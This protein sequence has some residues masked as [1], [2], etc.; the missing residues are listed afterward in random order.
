MS[1]KQDRA[2]IDRLVRE[3]VQIG[4]EL[5][6]A[7]TMHPDDGEELTRIHRKRIKA[8]RRLLY[9]DTDFPGSERP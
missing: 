2:R 1:D 9:D 8:I 7:G 3:L 4:R 6:G 5:E